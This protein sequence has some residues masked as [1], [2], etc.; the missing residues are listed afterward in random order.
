MPELMLLAE[1][2]TMRQESLEFSQ[3]SSEPRQTAHL[4]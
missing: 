1:D 3:Q 2:Q 4:F